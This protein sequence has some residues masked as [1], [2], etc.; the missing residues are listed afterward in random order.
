MRA[1]ALL[2][3]LM[4]IGNAEALASNAPLTVD[5]QTI[6]SDG[7]LFASKPASAAQVAT[8]ALP[9]PAAS[10]TPSTA[11]RGTSRNPLWAIPLTGL[12]ATREQPLFAP[13]RRPPAVAVAARP[14]A[15]PVTPPPGPPQPEKP[16]LSLLGTVAG[17]GGR[18]GLFIDSASKAVVRLKAG[19]NHQGWTLRDVR[20]HRVELAKGLDIA[21]LDLPAPDMKGG[22]N[23]PMQAAPA[24]MVAS[25]SP[26]SAGQP[27]NTAK[28]TGMPPS[29]TPAGV[30]RGQQPAPNQSREYANP[31]L[32][33]PRPR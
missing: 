22:P 14:A 29:V 32:Q 6:D 4:L 16:Q 21:V 24:P 13:S 30:P 8:P 19:E 1:L 25:P 27:I 10:P 5:A 15:A 28:A 33:Q 18:V 3:S 2:I 7:D 12:T 20:P 23:V 9:P 17:T 26:F 11:E 31:F